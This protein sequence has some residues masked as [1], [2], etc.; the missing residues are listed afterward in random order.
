MAEGLLQLGCRRL[1]KP[2][3]PRK[4]TESG[5]T[6]P[7]FRASAPPAA[8]HPCGL[9][10]ENP[11]LQ[12]LVVEDSELDFQLLAANLASQG[13][14]CAAERV[15][16]AAQLQAA[17]QRRSWDLV[18]SDHSLPGFS[19]GEAF[20][21][22]R[23]LP[24]PP[25]FI[26]VSGTIGEETAVEAMRRGVDDFLLKG[27]L[28]RLGAAAR[29]AI[30]A[31]RVRREKEAALAQLHES[32]KQLRDLSAQLQSRIDEER[33]AVSR[34]IHDEIGGTLT[35]VRFDL[36]MA[37]G[38]APGAPV[39]LERA[40]EALAQAQVAAQRIM[41]DLRPP[42]LDAGLV[43]ALEWHVRQFQERH[44]IEVRFETNVQSLQ[45]P[46]AL[47][48]TLYR[49]C[50]EALTNVSKHAG[51]SR[52]S[53]DLH[54]GDEVLSMEIEDNGRGIAEG[55]RAKPES[56]GLRGLA[57]RMRAADGHVEISSAPGRTTLMLWLPMPAAAGQEAAA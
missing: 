19:S 44:G 55:A 39:R 18:I 8:G 9:L 40:L 29:N 21:L 38:D 27:R 20:E 6:T 11:A 26:I 41:R 45:V 10:M 12:L 22:V 50:Q 30:A 16:T 13:L 15:E 35:A 43:A 37:A 28:L 48:M 3:A 4:T 25:P 23:A 24:S 42:I 57:E 1:W 36:E 54:L 32:Q 7:L 34:E 17:L 51:A 2:H 47:A 5:G 53:V 14:P 46:P 56:L 33:T 52:V 31:A 49:A